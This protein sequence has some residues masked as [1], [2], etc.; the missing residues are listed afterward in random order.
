M[1]ST[2]SVCFG[3]WHSKQPVM[4]KLISSEAFTTTGSA[5]TATAATGSPD[6]VEVA[7]SGG[8]IWVTLDGTTPASGTGFFLP[9][10]TTRTF[11]AGNGTV[12]KLIGPA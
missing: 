10:G 5:Q 12:V 8:D 2:V 1:A 6:C 7:T 3:S 9:D 11:D 4:T